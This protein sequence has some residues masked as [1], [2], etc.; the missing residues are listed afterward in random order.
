[1]SVKT[2]SSTEAAGV[3][4][5]RQLPTQNADM[6]R[7]MHAGADVAL[8]IAAA[9]YQAVALQGFRCIGQRLANG[10]IDRR[11]VRRVPPYLNRVVFVT[12]HVS[13]MSTVGDD[14]Q[15]FGVNQQVP[16]ARGCI[17]KR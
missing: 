16:H 7:I 3:G 4:I 8:C 2:G 1:M 11:P 15:T 5:D 17:Q 10:Q 9:A 14:E 6:E 13:R 12:A